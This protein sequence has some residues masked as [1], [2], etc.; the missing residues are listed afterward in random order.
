MAFVVGMLDDK[1]HLE[2]LAAL[3]PQAVA[4]WAVRPDYVRARDPQD[5][6]TAARESGIRA[7]A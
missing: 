4:L 1:D 5:I 6:V 3:A 2:T 7:Q